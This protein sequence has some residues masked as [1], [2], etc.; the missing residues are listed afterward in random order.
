ML[1]KW[2]QTKLQKRNQKK[3]FKERTLLQTQII[4]GV[5]IVV[6]MGLL[7]TGVWHGTRIASMQITEVAV[8]GGYTIP[9]SKIEETVRAQLMGTY[10]KLVPHS[11]R[12]T[13]PKDVILAHL[14]GISRMKHVTIEIVDT[15]KIVVTFEEYRPSSLWCENYD[16][17]ACLFLDEFGFA[18]SEAPELSGSAFMRYVDAATVPQRN[19]QAFET[20]FIA[21]SKVF[22]DLLAKELDLYVTYIEKVEELDV[23]YTV[24]GGGVLKVSQLMP[25]AD[26][27]KNLQSI[28]SSEEF[29]HLQNGAFQYIDL[30]FGDKI[31]LNEEK[32][33]MEVPE[34]LEEM[35]TSTDQ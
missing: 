18:F 12:M 28:L 35:A 24:S 2:R 15:Q 26:S 4:V 1:K 20:T 8:V 6:V 17:K 14:S 25:V 21:E 13:Y 22:A 34:V 10:F 31:F 30:R 5:S 33:V 23:L 19:Q 32:E 11:F 16:T 3:V 9:H 7:G 29:I 27:F